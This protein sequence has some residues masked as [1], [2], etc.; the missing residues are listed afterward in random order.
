MSMINPYQNIE[1][2][3]QP[4]SDLLSKFFYKIPHNQRE[5]RWK[6][7]DQIRRFW[8]DLAACVRKDFPGTSEPALGHFL[9]TVVVIGERQSNNTERHSV[10]D[11]QQRLTTISLLVRVLLEFVNSE[12]SDA[13]KKQRLSSK[14][15][16]CLSVD[17][18]GNEQP[19]LVLN[20][21]DEFYQE[22]VVRRAS[23]ADRDAYWQTVDTKRPAVRPRI[24]EALDFFHTQV[25]A[26]LEAAG[27]A[28]S[29]QR[30]NA[31][32]A[33]AYALCDYFYVLKI[34]VSDNRMAYRLFETLNERGLDLSQSD[35]VRNVVLEFA[36]KA[37]QSALDES[38]SS[39]IKLVD[40]VDAQDPALLTVPELIQF[41][42]TSRHGSVKAE[43]LFDT[44]AADLRDDKLKPV[45][46]V[47]GLEEDATLWVD[48]L[49]GNAAY[50]TSQAQESQSFILQIKPLWKKHAVP[51]LL[52]IADRFDNKGKKQEL[53]KALWALECYLFREGAIVGVPISE[54][55]SV[56]GEAARI[57]GD[58]TRPDNAFVSLLKGKSSDHRFIEKFAVAN[59]RTKLAFYVA[60]RIENHLFGGGAAGKTVSQISPAKQSVA[61]HLEH[62]M[63]KKPD[64]SWNGIEKKD[65]FPEYL[66]RLGNHLVLEGKINSAVK[67]KSFTH[68][69][70]NTENKD[71]ATQPL[72]L[73]REIYQ[74]K[75]DWY[76]S[77]SWD[78]ES[79]RQ[80]QEYLANEYAAKV[81]KIEW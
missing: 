43:K 7:D 66:D 78:F 48:F 25:A 8:D 76:P 65:E 61:Q 3:S 35:L 29:E 12:H 59:A 18:A 37:S 36:E 64:S 22:S 75:S 42:H 5:Y 56:L 70:K 38:S 53:G 47:K 16:S 1:P 2:E 69:L 30:D 63:P 15:M 11:G 46:F 27:D 45:S 81:W 73:P 4:T 79:I 74:R 10:I 72:K 33:L 50:W 14:L 17:I 80:R 41:S 19:R 32:D 52:R 55:E 39:W 68:K 9:G 71:Y 26:H 54:L 34:R 60:W 28:N 21:E 40:Q 23:K 51:L 49:Q 20:R 57:V 13:H 77:G 58:T 62:I 67:N 44:V 31:I 24:V 6:V